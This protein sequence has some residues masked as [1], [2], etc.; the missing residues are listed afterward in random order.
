VFSGREMTGY[1]LDLE[2]ETL[3]LEQSWQAM[4]DTGEP[5]YCQIN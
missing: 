3:S 5:L 1:V 4:M 2:S